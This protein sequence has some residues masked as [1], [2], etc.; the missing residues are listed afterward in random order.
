[1]LDTVMKNCG[2]PVHEEV[3]KRSFLEEQK[4]RIQGQLPE[5]ISHKLLDMIQTWGLAGKSRAEFALAADMYN[6]MK[7]S[8]HF[9]K[10]K[11][12]KNQGS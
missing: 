10:S 2:K 11:I 3:I 9:F 5:K 7:G 6:V 12:S 8:R 1:M 4:E